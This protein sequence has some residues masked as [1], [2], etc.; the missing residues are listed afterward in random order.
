MAR[1]SQCPQPTPQHAEAHRPASR[2]SPTG[3]QGKAHGKDSV[4]TPDGRERPA[5]VESVADLPSESYGFVCAKDLTKVPGGT[6]HADPAHRGLVRDVI[7]GPRPEMLRHSLFCRSRR[8]Y[9]AS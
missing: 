6:V 4:Q 3:R 7:H 5:E 1:A 9:R 8:E 2:Q